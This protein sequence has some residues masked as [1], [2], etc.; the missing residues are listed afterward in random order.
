[1][2]PDP[3]ESKLSRQPLRALPAF[4]REEILAAART[5]ATSAR[6]PRLPLHTPWWREL[7]S[8]GPY[9]WGALAAV[10]VVILALDFSTQSDVT[11]VLAESRSQPVPR[12]QDILRQKQQQ[13][14]ELAGASESPVAEPPKS[15]PPRPR[16]HWRNGIANA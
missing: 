9:A 10:W 8:P 6:A 11:P 5:A 1:M 12:L 14:A 7:V 4:W 3:L 2:K 16:S 13:Y 15:N